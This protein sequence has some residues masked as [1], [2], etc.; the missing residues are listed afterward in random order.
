MG[1]CDNGWICNLVAAQCNYFLV[2]YGVI[3]EGKDFLSTIFISC[4]IGGADSA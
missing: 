2:I 1:L 3:L 4:S